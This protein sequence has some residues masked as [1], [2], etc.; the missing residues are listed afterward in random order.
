MRKYSN[1]FLISTLLLGFTMVGCQKEI[2]LDLREA[3]TKYVLE[4]NLDDSTGFKLRITQS[5]PF[6]DDNT[7]NPIS[8]ASVVVSDDAGN[9]YTIPYDTSGY[10]ID[11]TLLAVVGRTYSVQVNDNGNEFSAKA[12]VPQKTLIKKVTIGSFNFGGGPDGPGIVRFL[13]VWYD[14]HPGTGDHYRVIYN[15]PNDPLSSLGINLQ[16]DRFGDGIETQI[17]IFG[18]R[19]DGE[20]KLEIGDTVSV[21]LQSIDKAAYDYL[22]TLDLISTDRGGGAITPTDPTSNWSNKALGVFIATT[23]DS[24]SVIIDK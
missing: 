20:G 3:A 13:Q 10:Y 4:G 7:F 12:T 19:D 8:T 6:Y 24:K 22:Y 9:S 5:K 1:L 18:G 15:N 16:D 17:L 21:S 2:Q 11:T 23:I 14:E